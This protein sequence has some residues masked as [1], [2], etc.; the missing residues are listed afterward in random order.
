MWYWP[1]K[2][3]K[4]ALVEWLDGGFD[5]GPVRVRRPRENLPIPDIVS[6]L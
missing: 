2:S 6:K 3:L 1:P 5:T 4:T